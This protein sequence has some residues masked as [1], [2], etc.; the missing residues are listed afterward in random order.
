MIAVIEHADEHLARVRIASG[1]FEGVDVPEGA[2]IERVCRHAEIVLADIAEHMFAA[3]QLLAH[4]IKGG[5]KTGVVGIDETH[6]RHLHDAGVEFAAA[7]AGG[8]GVAFVTPGLGEDFFLQLTGAFVPEQCAIAHGKMR[9]D[10]R[11]T[12]TSRPAHQR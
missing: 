3:P 12:M 11:Q 6:L 7:K 2:N 1:A 4:R 9:R 8:E 10:A 5:Q